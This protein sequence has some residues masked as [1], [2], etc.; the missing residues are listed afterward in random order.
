MKTRAKTMAVLLISGLFAASCAATSPPV[1]LEQEE[2]LTIG[3]VFRD[4][5]GPGTSTMDILDREYGEAL[6][7]GEATLAEQ[8]EELTIGDAFRDSAGPGTSTM[9]ILDREY[10]EALRGGGRRVED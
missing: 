3:D 1:F 7:V 8:E 10:G 4:R 9:D 5:A 6:N 2:E